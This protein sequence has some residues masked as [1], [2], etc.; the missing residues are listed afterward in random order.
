MRPCFA[1]FSLFRDRKTTCMPSGSKAIAVGIYIPRAAAMHQ[2]LHTSTQAKR[3]HFFHEAFCDISRRLTA[4]TNFF[5]FAQAPRCGYISRG[6]PDLTRKSH[7][8]CSLWQD[9]KP[10]PLN[11]QAELLYG[12]CHPPRPWRGTF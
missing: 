6:L 4:I 7:N 2:Q 11:Q 12:L 3:K 8:Y 9:L 1:L 10:G 5:T